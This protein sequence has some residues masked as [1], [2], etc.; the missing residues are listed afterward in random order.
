M[1]KCPKCNGEMREGEAF[2]SIET[3]SVQSSTNFGIAIPGMGTQCG[4]TIREEGIQWRE[5][6]GRKTGW[7]IKSD[8]EKIMR[9]LGMRC[10]ECGY[11][12]FYIQ[13]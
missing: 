13:K 8:E 7:F 1:V 5:K 6:T 12:E 2:I 4:E 10:T 3:S 11:V 9:I